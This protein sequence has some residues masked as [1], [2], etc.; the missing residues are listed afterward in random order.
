[1]ASKKNRCNSKLK[2]E[3]PDWDWEYWE[4]QLEGYAKVMKKP[5]WR[6]FLQTQK[7]LMDKVHDFYWEEEIHT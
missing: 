4:A 7:K 3:K 1:M 2:K 6:D 5:I